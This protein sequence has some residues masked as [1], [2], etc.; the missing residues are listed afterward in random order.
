[1]CG[2]LG[3]KWME[4]G[5]RPGIWGIYSL[6]AA[7]ELFQIHNCLLD[8]GDVALVSDPAYPSYEA[9]VKIAGGV[10][11]FY[12]LLKEN[13]FLPDLDAIPADKAK[14]AK[15]IWINIP[16]N[17]TTATA[18]DA[19]FIQ[20]IEWAREFEVWVVTDNPYMDICFDGYR[21]HSFLTFPGAKEVG[22]NLN[23]MSKSF[24]SCGWRVGILV[25]NKEII[26]GMEKIKSQS[27]RGLYYPLQVASIAALT[28]PIDWME[29]RN[30]RFT[31]RRDVIVKAWKE[32][33][34]EML[35]PRATFYCWGEIP[36]G[37]S[38]EGFS[39]RLLEESNVWMIPGST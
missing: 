34:L 6:G 20:L 8:P 18:D 15:M 30:K 5:G 23:S 39:F 12:P 7:E 28:G 27:D 16:H 11:E 26:S 31:E 22:V 1:M 32:M 36:Q 37:Y 3:Q 38:S 14:K 9:G 2:L 4:G 19:F 21:P 10:V 29:E 25:G 35:T 13:D 33:G 17:P 24:N